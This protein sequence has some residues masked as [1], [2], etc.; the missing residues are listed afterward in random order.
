MADGFDWENTPLPLGCS[1]CVEAVS[2][3]VCPCD[4]LGCPEA[5]KRAWLF[6]E[7]SGILEMK[8]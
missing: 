2:A 5:V 1:L 8:E 4:E 7:D 6:I 3:K